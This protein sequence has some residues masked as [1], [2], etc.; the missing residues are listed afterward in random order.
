VPGHAGNREK[1]S[2]DLGGIEFLPSARA[3]AMSISG[4][5]QLR[6]LGAPANRPLSFLWPCQQHSRVAHRRKIGYWRVPATPMMEATMLTTA[7]FPG[8]TR[9]I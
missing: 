7:R 9:D 8:S 2:V 6:L 1:L 4:D 5:K 3:G